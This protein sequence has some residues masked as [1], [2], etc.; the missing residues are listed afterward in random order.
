MK[1]RDGGK[2]GDNNSASALSSSHCRPN[3][4]LELPKVDHFECIQNSK[5]VPQKAQIPLQTAMVQSGTRENEM[6]LRL[7][8]M[9]HELAEVKSMMADSSQG[10]VHVPLLEIKGEGILF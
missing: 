6:Q 1:R 9:E 7:D 8:A 5:E 2:P 4:F 10:E 3:I